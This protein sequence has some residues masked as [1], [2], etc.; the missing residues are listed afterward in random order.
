M[1]WVFEII[2]WKSLNFRNR[3]DIYIQSLQ[4][5]HVCNKWL[6]VCFLN[7]TCL[8]EFVKDEICRYESFQ[9]GQR[10]SDG[11]DLWVV[12]CE[13]RQLM[14]AE[15]QT[16]TKTQAYSYQLQLKQSVT[17][18]V[19]PPPASSQLRESRLTCNKIIDLTPTYTHTQTL[20]HRTWYTNHRH[21]LTQR[22]S[23]V[24]ENTG[25]GFSVVF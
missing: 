7:L 5:L 3:T 20:S 11:D 2:G 4:A 24:S 8:L 10:L 16:E 22:E 14:A 21:R 1:Y 17:M 19:W 12:P 25:L 6:H 13:Q 9:G 18:P 15:L 23:F